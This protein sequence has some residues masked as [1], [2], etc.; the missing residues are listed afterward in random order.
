MIRP[1]SPADIAAPS[2]GS[3]RTAQQ[4]WGGEPRV[5]SYVAPSGPAGSS[6]PVI[7]EPWPLPEVGVSYWR[8]SGGWSQM[9]RAFV[10]EVDEAPLPPILARPIST[11]ANL[12]TRR[13]AGLIEQAIAAVEDSIAGARDEKV[14]PALRRDLRYWSARRSSMQ[15]MPSVEAPTS[16][17]FGVRAKIRRKG[18][19]REIYIVGEDEADPSAGLIAWTAP[20]ARAL[21]GAQAGET[22]DLEAGGRI[23]PVTVVSIAGSGVEE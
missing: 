11:A 10:K 6:P 9:S 7:N 4:S 15:I 13:G 5:A 3:P 12:V 18:T 23:E 19:T 16:V 22:V 21:Q 2:R 14:V 1:Q 20:L 8:S 17:M